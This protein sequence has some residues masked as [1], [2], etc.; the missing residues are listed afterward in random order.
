MV[1][2][3]VQVLAAKAVAQRRK[4]LRS[5]VAGASAN[6]LALAVGLNLLYAIHLGIK[7]E[8]GTQMPL[9]FYDS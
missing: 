1:V 7:K 2:A 9:V 5:L 4:G 8:V 6:T 3:A